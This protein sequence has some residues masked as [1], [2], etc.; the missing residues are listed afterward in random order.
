MGR[1]DP[2]T[3]SPVVARDADRDPEGF[4]LMSYA[5]VL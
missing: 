2:R 3:T 1:N 5:F 4:L